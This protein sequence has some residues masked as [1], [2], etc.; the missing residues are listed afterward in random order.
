M[1]NSAV[2]SLD[3]TQEE[4]ILDTKDILTNIEKLDIHCSSRKDAP[5][6]NLD[7][8]HAVDRPIRAGRYNTSSSYLYGHHPICHGT[9]KSIDPAA[10]EWDYNVPGYEGKRV[11]KPFKGKEARSLTAAWG[12]TTNIPGIVHHIDVH[13]KEIKPH[14]VLTI[15]VLKLN[16]Q[17]YGRF[18]VYRNGGLAG[19]EL[20]VHC[21]DPVCVDDY[22]PGLAIIQITLSTDCKPVERRFLCNNN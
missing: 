19:C 5:H 21:F 11:L 14:A 12:A 17:D 3:A 20:F 18:S 7:L 1:R 2:L 16:H 22:T 9:F 13:H 8:V 4:C 10:G 6:K 15:F